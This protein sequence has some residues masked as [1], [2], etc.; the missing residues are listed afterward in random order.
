MPELTDKK[1]RKIYN[2]LP[3]LYNQK[4]NLN[5]AEF[6][7]F[8]TEKNAELTKEL[9]LLLPKIKKAFKPPKKKKKTKEQHKADYENAVAALYG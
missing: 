6:A 1:G 4:S 3:E 2:F 5:E 7:S 9:K 8:V